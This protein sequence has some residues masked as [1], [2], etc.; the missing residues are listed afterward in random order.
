[1]FP[2]ARHHLLLELP[3]VRTQVMNET[4]QWITQRLTVQGPRI[5]MEPMK[6][7]PRY[8]SLN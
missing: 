8:E 6:M 3:E 2:G 7:S 5:K 1:M 4:V